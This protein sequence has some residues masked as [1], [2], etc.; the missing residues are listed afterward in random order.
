MRGELQPPRAPVVDSVCR[1]HTS[2]RPS[3][4]SGAKRHPFC[5][6]APVHSA[7]WK[8]SVTARVVPSIG[9]RRESKVRVAV[10]VLSRSL[11]SCLTARSA[12]RA[13]Q[14]HLTS[15]TR[16]VCS[17]TATCRR[18]T[19]SWRSSTAV[20][21]TWP[22]RWDVSWER[23]CGSNPRVR[24][25]ASSSRCLCMRRDVSSAATTKRSCWPRPLRSSRT[26][27]SCAHS[28]ACERLRRKDPREGRRVSRTSVELSLL[29]AAHWVCGEPS[30]APSVGW[31]TTC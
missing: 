23:G 5:T 7:R 20:G 26:S 31:W 3:C 18:A 15:L 16:R 1:S 17:T 25:G 2:S 4:R 6:R 29:A 11:R 9:C 14:I 8:T 21:A 28:L 10:V 22:S 27:R 12:L 13:A 24:S 30:R 19:G